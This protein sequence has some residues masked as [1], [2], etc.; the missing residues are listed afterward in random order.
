MTEAP[1]ETENLELYWGPA[2]GELLLMPTIPAPDSVGRPANLLFKGG[3]YNIYKAE[4]CKNLRP[5]TGVAY[6]G[7]Y[8][9]DSE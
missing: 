8:C 3:W 4:D 7:V 5:T 2:D 6:I 9:D 1:S